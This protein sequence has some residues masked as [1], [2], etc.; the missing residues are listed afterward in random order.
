MAEKGNPA[1]GKQ[2]K[3]K[4]ILNELYLLV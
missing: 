2:E 1:V 3:K 4:I